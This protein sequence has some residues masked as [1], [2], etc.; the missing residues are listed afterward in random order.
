VE[1]EEGVEL[2]R[3]LALPERGPGKQREAEVDRRRIEG[4]DGL[5]QLDAEGF[6]RIEAPR[7]RNQALGEVGSDPPVADLVGMG[8][9]VP[10]DHAPEAH[11]VQLGL[12]HAETGLDV[13]QAL[14]VRELGEGQAEELVPAGEGLHLVVTVVP[15]HA[16]A[17]IVRRHEVYQLGEDRAAGVHGRAPL[18]Q[19]REYGPQRVGGS[20]R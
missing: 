11:V 1:I 17:E 4:V 8:Q 3:A 2:H 15:R 19:R 18:A 10:R 13:A 12:G 5:V 6:G 9:G 16:D 7:L 20:N 14:P